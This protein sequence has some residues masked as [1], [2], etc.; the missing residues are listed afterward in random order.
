VTAPA[1]H[2]VL[3]GAVLDEREAE[4]CRSDPERFDHNLLCTAHQRR[5]APCPALRGRP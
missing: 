4:V 1:K 2:C 5:F 3:C